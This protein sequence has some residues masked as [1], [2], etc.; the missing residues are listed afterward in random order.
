MA[1]LPVPGADD[2]TWGDILNAYL[3]VTHASD[4]TLNSNVVG[5]SQILNNAVT[6]AQLD[7]ATQTIL[8]SVA[9]KYTL[10]AGGIPESDLDSATQTKIDVGASAYQKPVGGIPGSDLDSSVQSDLASASTAVQSVNSKAGT[11]VTLSAS[12]IS[13]VPA[14]Q[15]GAASG[16]ATLN[17]SSQLTASQLPSIA[18]NA[19]AATF[20]NASVLGASKRPAV[21]LLMSS[22]DTVASSTDQTAAFQS[23]ISAAA[24]IL[25]SSSVIKV[26][27]I[28]DSR[29]KYIIGGAVQSGANG[30]LAQ[31]PL[32]YSSGAV[33]G[34][35]ELVGFPGAGGPEWLIL[36]Y[37]QSG[38][39][40]E[41]TLASAPTFS[42]STGIAST[43][44]GPA[45]YSTNNK[46]AQS[47]ICFSVKNVEIRSAAPVICGIDTG[48]LAGFFFDGLIFNTDATTNMNG[49]S[50]ALAAYT[51]MVTNLVVTTA[52]QA[53]PIIFPLVNCVYGA[54]GGMLGVANWACGPVIGEWLDAQQID[55]MF[56]PGPCLAVDV[57]SHPNRIG[58]LG[59][60]DNAYGISST[61]PT[62]G[63]N[64]FAPTTTGGASDTTAGS[65]TASM[66]DIGVWDVQTAE[67]YA[68]NTI[69]RVNDVLDSNGITPINAMA[70]KVQGGTGAI[71]TKQW[72]FIGTGAS[73]AGIMYYSK[74]I[75]K[76]SAIGAIQTASGFP[77]TSGTTARNP[78]SRDCLV[79]TSGGTITNYSIN[80]SAFGA[81]PPSSFL[82][83]ANATFSITYTGTPAMSFM[84]I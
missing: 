36:G 77:K 25:S 78:I 53:I 5:T 82:L 29:Q 10:P 42:A 52:P 35:I 7:S 37:G 13:A 74:I 6:N 20:T 58:M 9:G 50:G 59:D 67:S 39:V 1:R 8:S 34:T 32:P 69:K 81:A 27:I 70:Q 23:A 51:T 80:G 16:V 72:S 2:G 38:T 83:P 11:S 17:A 65:N 63:N 79:Y 73:A 40:I 76:M 3:S 60:W 64:P 54:K 68:P 21:D 43:F 84:A 14:S 45:S 41:S 19:S 71:L 31:I 66:L 46:N 48:H 55:V 44:G 12:D 30:Q 49:S 62:S 4:G 22:Y 47:T 15:L 18:G 56:C 24:N 57:S 75:D 33:A 26:R 61:Y 28:L